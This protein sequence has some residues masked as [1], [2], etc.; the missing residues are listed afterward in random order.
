[1]TT[2]LAV[3]TLSFAPIIYQVFQFRYWPVDSMHYLTSYAGKFR[4]EGR[5]LNFLLN[6]A[7]LTLPPKVAWSVGFIVV[8]TTLF[9]LSK[10]FFSATADR[11]LFVLILMATPGWYTQWFWPH[12]SLTSILLLLMAALA[13]QRLPYW[14]VFP[15]TSVLMFGGNSAYIYFLPLLYFNRFRDPDFGKA[16][17][18]AFFILTTWLAS[19]VAGYAVALCVTWIY[20]GTGLR[21]QPWRQ[22]HPA[23]DWTSLGENVSRSAS[24]FLEQLSTIAPY[25]GYVLTGLLCSHL[26]LRISRR[27]STAELRTL[28]VPSAV[29]ICVLLSHHLSVLYHGI[30]I[31]HRTLA[32][33]YVG[34][35]YLLLTQSQF[36]ARRVISILILAVIAIPMWCQS[37]VGVAWFAQ[38]AA[39]I[40]EDLKKA[41]PSTVSTEDN[42]VFDTRRFQA[43]YHEVD[44][45]VRESAA[46]WTS[47]PDL[48][49]S[50]AF[51]G[52]E[53]LARDA[54]RKIY[55]SAGFEAVQFCGGVREPNR[56]S[57]RLCHQLFVI[58]ARTPCP[59]GCGRVQFLGAHNSDRFMLALRTT[60]RSV[61]GEERAQRNASGRVK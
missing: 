11:T 3:V 9:L 31:H 44:R 47:R 34:V 33:V 26:I 5:W 24:S 1:M 7:L 36:L 40:A 18:S 27:T 22:P 43:N 14:C 51:F 25:G 29:C 30:T 49:P 50:Y 46:F 19:F 60:R 8:A 55:R 48:G 20:F 56:R 2:A 23:T 28:V 35:V 32:H 16:L 57:G 15:V 12:Y 42:L 52:G 6:D 10:Q 53:R 21:F 37:Y 61:A 17:R 4:A 13:S 41:L 45:L 38:H 39:V 54:Y 59:T 58:S